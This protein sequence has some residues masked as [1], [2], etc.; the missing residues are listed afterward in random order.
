[1]ST[2]REWERDEILSTLRSP[3]PGA[4]A[5]P[6]DDLIAILHSKLTQLRVEFLVVG[7]PE[8]GIVKPHVVF[9][10]ILQ[11]CHQR[12]RFKQCRLSM[13]YTG[14]GSNQD[15]GELTLTGSGFIGSHHKATGSF[16]FVLTPSGRNATVGSWIKILLGLSQ[17]QQFPGSI[18]GDLTVFD[19]NEVQVDA[20]TRQQMDGCRDWIAQAFTRFYLVGL[21]T[22]CGQD[23][24]ETPAL[25]GGQ[26]V[27]YLNFNQTIPSR[28]T[29]IQ[30]APFWF[31]DIIDK[32]FTMS[33][34]PQ[35]SRGVKVEPIR[36]WRGRFHDRNV[37][38]HEMVTIY[39]NDGSQTFNF[40]YNYHAPPRTGSSGGSSGGQ[41]GGAGGSSGHP[42]SSSSGH[43]GGGSQPRAT[44][45]AAQAKTWVSVKVN[46]KEKGVRDANAR[47]DN[48]GFVLVYDTK[49]VKVGTYNPQTKVFKST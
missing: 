16:G 37:L 47:P 45:N 29:G 42:S 48:N 9:H 23:L 32:K 8:H 12:Q 4:G 15:G 2:S 13:E 40:R 6:P 39:S 30:P 11:P 7:S 24:Q 27:T 22:M 38:R 35:H 19:F 20:P 3:A 17:T 26:P 33:P 41:T 44:S 34:D 10:F 49:K 31:P 36:M 18:R 21:V 25:Y 1:M 46:G 43:G 14:D 5:T 28:A